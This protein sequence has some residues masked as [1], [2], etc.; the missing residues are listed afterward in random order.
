MDIC[1]IQE[2]SDKIEITFC[3]E[4]C[5][6]VM[7]IFITK[8]DAWSIHR[9]CGDKLSLRARKAIEKAINKTD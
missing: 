4:D 1:D 5:D 7:R 2:I 3:N 9:F 8:S 6:D